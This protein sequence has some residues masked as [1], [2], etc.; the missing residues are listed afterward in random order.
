M[1]IAIIVTIVVIF[2][3][4]AFRVPI[5]ASMTLTGIILMA[6]TTG[7]KWSI[8]VQYLFTGLDSF[9]LLAIPLFLL[10]AKIMNTSGI[11]QKLFDFCM[12]VVG[13][14]PGGLG[15]VNLLVSVVFAGMSGTAISDAAGLGTIEIAAMKE[16]GFD[17]E[18][19]CCVTAASS[20][21]GPI[22]PPRIP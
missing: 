17:N 1:N 22:I 14:L 10:A 5:W 12:K 21:L 16:H 2:I 20:T 3:L 19:S 15:H 4:F 7:M 9:T 18:F 8:P 11:T 13:W 6:L